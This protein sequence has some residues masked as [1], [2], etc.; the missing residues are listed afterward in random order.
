MQI[1]MA[2]R[3]HLIPRGRAKI[4]TSGDNTHSESSSEKWK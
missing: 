1:N 4:K 3:N 2:L